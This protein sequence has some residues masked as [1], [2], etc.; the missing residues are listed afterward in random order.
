MNL[1]TDFFLF[2]LWL[3][4]IHQRGVVLLQ[5]PGLFAAVQ[6]LSSLYFF[7]LQGEFRGGW[8]IPSKWGWDYLRQREKP[9]YLF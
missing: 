9:L 4:F 8:C 6:L 1:L 3:L 2:F 5:K 7:F